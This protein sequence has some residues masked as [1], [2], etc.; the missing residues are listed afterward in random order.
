[1]QDDIQHV[2]LGDREVK[3]WR[4]SSNKILL[5]SKYPS[6]ASLK[7]DWNEFNQMTIEDQRESDWKSI[8]LFQF[9]NLDRYNKMMGEFLSKDI[10]DS[11][12]DNTYRSNRPVQESVLLETGSKRSRDIALMEYAS[13]SDPITSMLTCSRI[14]NNTILEYTKTKLEDQIMGVGLGD[15]E[16][17]P[18]FT[19]RELEKIGVSTVPDCEPRY[20]NDPDSVYDINPKTWIAEYKNAFKGIGCSECTTFGRWKSAID[21][22]YLSLNTCKELGLTELANRSKQDI[23]DLGWNPEIPFNEVTREFAKKRIRTIAKEEYSGFKMVDMEESVKLLSEASSSM[24]DPSV[25]K[26]LFIVFF[27]SNTVFNKAVRVVDKSPYNHVAISFDTSLKKLYSFSIIDGGGFTIESIAKHAKNENDKAIQVY[28]IFISSEQY[29][30]VKQNLEYFNKNKKKYDYSLINLVTIPLKINYI[31]STKM[32][33]SQFADYILKL[34]SYD[35]TGIDSNMVSPGTLN[36][37]IRSK[38]YK[39]VVYRVYSGAPS[40]YSEAKLSKFVDELMSKGSKILKEMVN[41]LGN[42]IIAEAK[43]FPIQFDDDGNLLIKKGWNIDFEAEYSKCHLAMKQ[44]DK[45]DNVEAMKYCLCKL[46]YLNILLEE[47]IHKDK[48]KPDKITVY[49]KVRAKII[50]DITV[51]M[52]KVQKLDKTFDLLKYYEQSPFSDSEIKIR[53]S[54]LQNVI[55]MFKEL[56]SG[57]FKK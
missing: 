26:A 29:K 11:L 17:T 40:E 56:L 21:E 5:Y 12:Y 31:K 19:P 37:S 38:K 27:N 8:D 22:L 24:A 49:N 30:I 13:I 6:M 52:K 35:F 23:L 46:W 43:E 7:D 9:P 47:K 53:K 25:G 1:M 32:V 54:T 57:I 48:K 4:L 2:E 20:S 3:D 50:N 44:Y 36:K 33:C 55:A 34:A 51:Y 45:A 42:V 10:D 18:Y 14:E 16:I 28:T 39:G 15:L 41:L